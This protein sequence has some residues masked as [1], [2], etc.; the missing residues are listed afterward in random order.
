MRSI[1]L[2]GRDKKRGQEDMNEHESQQPLPNVPFSVSELLG[3]VS[4]IWGYVKYLKTL[5][6][7]PEGEERIAILERV[8]NR[9]QAELAS[10]NGELRMPLNAEEVTELLEAMIGFIAQIKRFFPK[11]RER[12]EVINTVNYWRL[13]MIS[14]ITEHIE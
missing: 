2:A 12:D 14:I 10:G 7:S 8:G 9:L 13:R 6:P 4:V 3:I 5:P 1:L 11:N